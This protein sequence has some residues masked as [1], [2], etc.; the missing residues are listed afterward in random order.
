MKVKM[1]TLL[2]LSLSGC[3]QS[4][5]EIKELLIGSKWECQYLN[6]IV[7]V[8]VNTNYLEDGQFV[9]NSI[10][11]TKLADNE[12][13]AIVKISL[14]GSWYASGNEITLKTITTDVLP[15]NNS[16]QQTVGVIKDALVKVTTNEATKIRIINKDKYFDV[17]DGNKSTC[18]RRKDN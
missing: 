18:L 7:N 2:I 16:G 13:D 14:S 17:S 10:V 9:S 1:M 3:E 8:T 4:K 12:K 15:I 6:E 11:R 5:P